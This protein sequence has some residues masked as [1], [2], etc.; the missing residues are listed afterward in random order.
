MAALPVPTVSYAQIPAIPH[1]DR[2]RRGQ[3]TPD[4]WEQVFIQRLADHGLGWLAAK[5]AGVSYKTVQRLRELDPQFREDE[6]DAMAE[7]TEGLQG[8]LLRISTGDDM[9]AV[10]ANIVMLKKRDPMGFCEKNL[11]VS[12]SFTTELPADDGRALLHAMLGQPMT[13]ALTERTE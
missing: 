2:R 1:R 12:A 5:Q 8:N 7:S 11:A 13:Q 4:G 3:P 10:T 6:A 9:P